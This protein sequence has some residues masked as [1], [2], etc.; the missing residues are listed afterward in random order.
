[1]EKYAKISAKKRA[2]VYVWVSCFISAVLT[3]C[4]APRS[5][6]LQVVLLFVCL[7][8][9]LAL[10]PHAI[11]SWRLVYGAIYGA[12]VTYSMLL[13]G[14]PVFLPLAAWHNGWSY[15]FKVLAPN[16]QVQ[17]DVKYLAE[18]LNKGPQT[19][20]RE[21]P[22]FDQAADECDCSLPDGGQEGK[23]CE[24]P[25]GSDWKPTFTVVSALVDIGRKTRD[26]CKY[27]E[28][29]YPHLTRDVP[30]VI[31][32]EAWAEPFVNIVRTK[33][34]LMDRTK[35]IVL[36]R[37]SKMAFYDLLPKMQEISDR[38]HMWHFLSN[39]AGGV[40]GK[41]LALYG[42]INHQKVDFVLQAAEANYFGTDYFVWMDAGAGH[43]QKQVPQHFC[44]C[45]IAL[46]GTVTL[47]MR[48]PTEEALFQQ[49]AD[50]VGK[51]RWLSGFVNKGVPLSQLN[52]DSYVTKYHWN[53]DF[54][55]IIGTMWGGDLAGIRQF[56][57]DYKATLHK[58][59]EAE[60]IDY[61]Q[62]VLAL[63]AASKP[64]YLRFIEN[65]YYGIELLC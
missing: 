30:M 29:F 16:H 7:G 24:R 56:Y 32:T 9:L 23:W 51:Q 28:W 63:V 25:P 52:L 57:H 59:L 58:L 12:L 54:Q 20:F 14:P 49:G 17:C 2:D 11:A 21:T 22:H 62:A 44:A 50:P 8:N 31:Y 45:N 34:G 33:W 42:W 13:A 64:S 19:F 60:V 48:A 18:E 36:T 39:Y 35:V 38:N 3:W 41:T 27:L 1:M 6:L 26:P 43:G 15:G 53:H 40:V 4:W 65:N 55:E 5:K 61:D 37:Q 46:P 47:S 10:K